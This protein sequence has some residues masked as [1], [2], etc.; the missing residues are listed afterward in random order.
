MTSF[1]SGARS[2]FCLFLS[3]FITVQ[4][5]SYGESNQV[6]MANDEVVREHPVNRLIPHGTA[7]VSVMNLA[8][9]VRD[10]ELLMKFAESSQINLQRLLDARENAKP[11]ERL[12]YDPAM[13]LTAMEYD[14][15]YDAFQRMRLVVSGEAQLRFLN[16]GPGRYILDGGS[17]LREMTGLVIE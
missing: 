17:D 2:A 8:L 10:Q 11:G 9:S 12:P 1:R 5:S 15:L 7:K 14:E 3:L 13:G 4:S 6:F 16:D